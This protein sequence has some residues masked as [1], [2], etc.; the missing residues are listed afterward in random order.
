MQNNFRFMKRKYLPS[1]IVLC[2]ITFLTCC[3]EQNRTLLF[4]GDT[5]TAGEEQGPEYTFPELVAQQL[6]G[7][8][9]L[10]QGRS[11]WSTTSYLTRWDEVEEDFPSNADFVFIQLGINDLREGGYNDSTITLCIK[12]MEEILQRIRSHYPDAEIVLMS[13]TKIDPSAIS[14]KFAGVGFGDITNSYLSRIAAGYS[15]IA[16]DNYCNFIDLHRLVPITSTLDGVHLNKNGHRI[17]AQVILGL[18]REL[19]ASKQN[20]DKAA[21]EQ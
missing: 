16:A 8:R 1:L 12:N 19:M 18:L 17:A 2:L 11:D 7:F 6:N 21:D 9:S 20:Q 14:E 4:L 10:S 5:L 15:I 13:S 3:K